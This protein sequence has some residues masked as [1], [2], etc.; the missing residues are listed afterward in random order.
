MFKTPSHT[1]SQTKDGG[2]GGQEKVWEV[3]TQYVPNARLLE[4]IN[5]EVTYSLPIH[6]TLGNTNRWVRG[7]GRGHGGVMREN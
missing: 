7:S 3:V 5:G 4:N 1:F 2:K 6:D